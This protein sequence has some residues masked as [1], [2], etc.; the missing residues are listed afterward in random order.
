MKLAYRSLIGCGVFGILNALTFVISC[1]VGTL[2][3]PNPLA[4]LAFATFFFGLIFG[5]VGL[6]G[7][8][9]RDDYRQD[10][11]K[12]IARDELSKR[13]ELERLERELGLGKDGAS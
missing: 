13:R 10:E 1:Y 3:G 8:A 2:P 11:R 9:M 6:G 7:L 12:R 4:D 5:A